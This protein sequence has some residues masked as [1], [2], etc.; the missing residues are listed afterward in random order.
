MHKDPHKRRGL[1]GDRRETV[2][3]V[4]AQRQPD[5]TVLAE[6]LPAYQLELIPEQVADI[7]DTLCL[8]AASVRAALTPNTKA[9]LPV[10]WIGL[11][12]DMDHICEWADEKGLIVLEDAAHAHGAVYKGK[13]IGTLADA[14]VLSMQGNKLVPSAEGGMRWT[15]VWTW[16][17]PGQPL[18]GLSCVKIRMLSWLERFVISKRLKSELRLP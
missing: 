7:D 5:L 17:G 14:A 11:P 6:N 12:A 16:P 9:V 18:Y 13:K 15:A 3:R 10:H 1:G 2:D 8:D 4:L